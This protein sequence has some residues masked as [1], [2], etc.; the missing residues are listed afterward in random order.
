MLTL[1][2]FE[3][4]RYSLTPAL[5]VVR[6]SAVFKPDTPTLYPIQDVKTRWNSTFLM[7]RRARR[8]RNI[9][10]PFCS[11]YDRQDLALSQDE[12]R[13][14][15]YLLWITEPFFNF[16]AALSKTKDVTVH[17]I[18]GIY[19]KLFNH[20]EKSTRQL[21]RKKVPWKKVMLTALGAATDKLSYYYSRTDHIRGD[22]FAI[23]TILAPQ[24]KLQFFNGKDWGTS[25]R[26]QYRQSLERYLEPYKERISADR[27]SPQ[28][29][30][31]ISQS[32]DIQLEMML[33]PS[34]LS[35][36]NRNNELQ[37]YLESGKC[38]FY[39]H[40]LFN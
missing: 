27:L 11:D 18:F 6:H 17:L 24:H 33:E 9:F 25:Y 10:D 32:L 40:R 12:W 38:S 28:G 31:S 39:Y 37:R 20:L 19:N 7:L 29:S 36:E 1:M 13:Q 4:L 30:S 8:L 35:T 22:L 26:K 2:R 21:Q 15:E 3:I 23:G 16:T 5:S 34:N 14:I